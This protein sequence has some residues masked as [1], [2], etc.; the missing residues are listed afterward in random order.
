[1]N[2]RNYQ[3]GDETGINELHNIT[4]SSTRT[5]DKWEW[6]FKQNPLGRTIFVVTEDNGEIKGSQSLIPA[7]LNIKG[8]KTY[9]AKSEAT[10]LHPDCRGKNLFSRMYE[11]AFDEAKKDNIKI[12]WGFTNAVKS[13][14]KIGF[15]VTTP[16]SLM[17]YVNNIGVA[18]RFVCRKHIANRKYKV[19]KS[20]AALF[21]LYFLRIYV[22]MS[23]LFSRSP[24]SS[25]GLAVKPLGGFNKETDMLFDDFVGDFP[26]IITLWRNKEDLQWRTTA[27]PAGEQHIFGLFSNEKLVGYAVI[28]FNKEERILTLQDMIVRK[29]YLH[30]G[31]ICLLNKIKAFAKELKA[32]LIRNM[33]VVSENVISKNNKQCLS[34]SGFWM[35]PNKTAT[36]IKVIN[37]KMDKDFILNI[38]NWY[39][40]GLFTEGF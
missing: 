5:L 36:V 30:D 10:L 17:W 31:S 23:G 7:Y 19:L 1:M 18:W 34:V 24:K 9:S 11:L 8:E 27:N 25:G 28:I 15:S 35:M 2:I 29:Q 3:N 37:D 26:D 21:A 38:N 6:E 40:T 20:I 32:G 39:I 4:Y 33:F 14:N 16:V 13:F 22:I 12:V